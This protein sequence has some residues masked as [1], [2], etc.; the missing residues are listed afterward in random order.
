MNAVNITITCDDSAQAET[1]ARQI[2][3]QH[4]VSV[5]VIRP[6]HLYMLSPKGPA[7][8]CVRVTGGIVDDE[9]FIETSAAVRDL[10]DL[11]DALRAV[12]W[13][14]P[15]A[16]GRRPSRVFQLL[17]LKVQGSNR[18]QQLGNDTGKEP[19]VGAARFIERLLER[20]EQIPGYGHLGRELVKKFRQLF[21]HE[22][23]P[24]LMGCTCSVGGGRPG[25]VEGAPPPGPGLDGGAK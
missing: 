5:T 15:H 10:S 13:A 17:N 24:P 1:I 19:V 3:E 18:G 23:S 12:D 7:E 9:P 4:Q 21:V 6:S 25:G 16:A 8:P 11:T 2:V 20:V 22:S 14:R